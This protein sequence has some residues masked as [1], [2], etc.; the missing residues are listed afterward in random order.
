MDA[1]AIGL[2]GTALQTPTTQDH[3]RMVQ[4]LLD[5]GAYIDTLLRVVP[6]V[7]IYSQLCRYVAAGKGLETFSGLIWEL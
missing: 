3:E 2:Q 5:V 7:V 6:A 4:L 1:V